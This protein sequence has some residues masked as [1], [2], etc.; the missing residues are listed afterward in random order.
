MSIHDFIYTFVSSFIALFPVMNPVGSG[1][2]VNGFLEDLDDTHRN[3]YIKKI[4]TYSFLIGIGSLLAGHFI[5]LIFGLAIPVI[6]LGGGL[7][8]CKTAIGWLSSSETDSESTQNKQKTI[9]ELNLQDIE[10]KLFYPI[11]FPISI[12]P[13]SI[14]VIFTLMAA[15]SVKGSFLVTGIHYL[16]IVLAIVAICAILYLFLSQGR[17]VMK[18][19]GASGNMI[20]NKMVAFFTFCIGIQI[21]VTGIA[22]IFHLEIL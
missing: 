20:I 22:K 1:F 11:T 9:D 10:R 2:I 5:L 17:R 4:I 6:Q 8:I 18:R 3:L 19:L 7:I 14:S 13:G 16:F 21:V 12:G 15:A